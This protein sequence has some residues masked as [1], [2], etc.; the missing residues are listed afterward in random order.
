MPLQPYVF[1]NG[2]CEEAIDFYK[3]ALGAKVNMLMRYKEC[4]EPM[5][6]M[7]PENADKVMHGSLSIGDSVL[8]MSDGRCDM[9]MKFDGFALTVVAK[10]EA[11]AQTAFNAL[12]DGGKV[13]MPLGKTFF[14]PSFG[15]LSDRFGVMWMVIVQ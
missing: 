6:G 14:S 7:K 13:N 15:M 5:P 9:P 4:P 2:R 12:A 8:L 1:Y 10:T 3:R 11:E